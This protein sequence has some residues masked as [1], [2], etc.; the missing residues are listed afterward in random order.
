[1]RAGMTVRRSNAIH[2]TNKIERY[3]LTAE[4]EGGVE[5]LR[6]GV[7]RARATCVGR[8]RLQKKRSSLLGDYNDVALYILDAIRAASQSD[9]LVGSVLGRSCSA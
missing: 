8:A 2:R 6:G 3:P 4:E 7:S 5:T 1:M 9:G